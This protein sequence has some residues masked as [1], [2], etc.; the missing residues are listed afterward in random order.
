MVIVFHVGYYKKPWNY[1]SLDE[2]ALGGT[3][4]SVI[5]LG[6]YLATHHEVF[7]VGNVLDSKSAKGVNY[8]SLEQFHSLPAKIELLIGVS[9]IHFLKYYELRVV[10]R[11]WFWMHNTDYYLWYNGQELPSDNYNLNNEAIDKIVCLSNWHK[12]NTSKVFNVKQ[13]RILVLPNF[14]NHAKFQLWSFKDKIPY[15]FI[16][17]S[18][19][20]RSLQKVLS[21]WPTIKKKYPSA[22]L[23]LSTPEYGLDYFMDHYFHKTLEF[24]GIKFYGALKQSELYRLM[25]RC[26]VWYYPTDYEETFCITAIEMMGHGVLPVTSLK[27]SLN[28]VIG[29]DKNFETYDA[30]FEFLT[31]QK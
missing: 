29:T 10:S 17:T 21:E 3:E 23:H 7:V 16:Y 1:K 28:E 18:H 11:K 25:S 22:S 4:K 5:L 30:A 12:N 8:T 20:E 6:D 9:Y 24:Q 26:Q 27:A 15:S 2:E 19:A 31:S 13:D 14:V